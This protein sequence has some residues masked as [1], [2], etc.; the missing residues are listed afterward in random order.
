MTMAGAS[1]K[2]IQVGIVGARGYVGADLLRLLEPHRLFKIAFVSSRALAGQRVSQHVE[3]FFDRSIRFEDL[4]AQGVARRDANA[5]VLALPNGL[6][7]EYVEEIDARGDD[8]TVII[9]VSADYRFDDRWTYGLPE[10][11]RRQIQQATRI[12]NPGCYATGMQLAIAPLLERLAAPPTVFGV[13]GYSGA[14]T[15]PSEKNDPELLHDNLMPYTLV[16]HTHERE[17]SHHLGQPVHFMP[18][19]APFFRGI[20]LTISMPLREPID[21]DALRAVYRDAY[22]DEP[23]VRLSDRIPL[24]RNIASRHHVEIGGFAADEE[25]SRVVVVV[26]L[27]N[28]LKGAATQAVQNMNLACGM[29]DEL[30]GIRSWLQ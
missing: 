14:G 29:D 21:V 15:T 12:S 11:H 30:E 22:T 6:A 8:E 2:I 10:L 20:T 17:V 5:Y 25:A 18:H 4:D 27:D 19:V 16:R 23:L 3:E 1:R 24:V 9:D 26:T 28:L 13:S 7:A